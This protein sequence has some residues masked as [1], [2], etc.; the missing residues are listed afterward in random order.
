MIQRIQTLWLFLAAMAAFFSIKYPF[1]VSPE[2]ATV[3]ATESNLFLLILSAALGTGILIAIFLFKQRKLQMRIVLLCAL[4]EC[5]IIFLYSRQAG[6]IENG[7]YTAA[8]ILHP[9]ILIL[10]FLAIRG[11]YKDHKLIQ[12][13]NRLR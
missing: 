6:E 12:E 3:S 2:G 9:V 8:A 5:L 7:S 13:S 10:L 1:Y 4:V 11:I